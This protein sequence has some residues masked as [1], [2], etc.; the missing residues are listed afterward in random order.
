MSEIIIIK[1]WKLFPV[2]VIM[3]SSGNLKSERSH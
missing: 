1:Q 3:I 2:Y